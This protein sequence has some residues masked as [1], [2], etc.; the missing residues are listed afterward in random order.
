MLK[1]TIQNIFNLAGYKIEKKD[2]FYSNDLFFKKLLI[3]VK[4]Y[5]MTNP[6]RIF[7]LYNAINHIINNNIKGD[8]VECG[9]WRGGSI[10]TIAL[11]LIENKIT[12]KNILLYDTF[13]GMSI[14]TNNDYL[15]SDK[16]KLAKNLIE[17]DEYLKCISSISEVKKNIFKT[18]YPKKKFKFIV[19]DVKET[20]KKKIPQKISLLRLDTDWYESTKKELN[21]LFPKLSKGGVLIIDDYKTWGG[22]KKAVDEYFKNKKNVFFISI[23]NEALLGIKF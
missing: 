2:N 19:G 16:S 15:F 14:P 20:L 22:C 10:M 12:D 7:Y 5:T 17:K 21:V 1:N 6:K 23:D 13:T 4:N 9:V 11:T 18:N 3:K 8:I